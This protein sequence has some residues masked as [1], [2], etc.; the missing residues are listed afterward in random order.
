M[1]YLDIPPRLAPGTLAVERDAATLQVGL[2]R[3]RAVTLPR[4]PE[5][6]C[7]LAALAHPDPRTPVSREVLERLDD[8]GLLALPLTPRVRLLPGLRAP[9]G[10]ES[11]LEAAGVRID[12]AAGMVLAVS[13]GEPDRDLLDPLVRDGVPHLVARV[14]DGAAVLGPYVEAGRS[15]CLRC[16]DRHDADRDPLRPRLLAEHRRAAHA[17]PAPVL[18]GLLAHWVAA[19]L[20]ALAHDRT[21]ATLDATVRLPL[22]LTGAES[23]RWAVHPDCG[24]GWDH[25]ASGVESLGS[26]DTMAS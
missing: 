22:L 12:D 17:E 10:L 21:P 7:T 6:L 2:D 14:L 26:R 16:L 24:C 1:H 9:A 23:T 15:A 3:E 5:V 20:M 11:V 18:V 19:D 4:T 13:V 25:R 8:A